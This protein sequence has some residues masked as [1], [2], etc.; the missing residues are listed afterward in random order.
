MKPLSEVFIEIK[1]KSKANRRFTFPIKY[2]R[3]DNTVGMKPMVAKVFV[4]EE[5]ALFNR[6]VCFHDYETGKTFKIGLDFWLQYNGQKI[7][8][9]K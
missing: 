4:G 6:T 1:E 3:Q 7:D 8:H 9:T 2:V 5:N